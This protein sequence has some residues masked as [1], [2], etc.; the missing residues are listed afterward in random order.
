[1]P[2]SQDEAAAR[3]DSAR[4]KGGPPLRRMLI[5]DPACVQ[6]IGHNV[7]AMKYFRDSLAGHYD[8]VLAF[9]CRLLPKRA[10]ETHSLVPLFGFYYDGYLK[11]DRPEPDDDEAATS[12]E[13]GDPLE[14]MATEDSR[15][16]LRQ[17]AV[18]ADDSV[19]FPHLDFY[20]VLG[21]VNAL[22]ERPR[23]ICPTLYLRYIGVME[24]ASHGF[25]NPLAELNL[26]VREG[27]DAGLRIQLCAETPSY[28]DFISQALAAPV[29]VVPIPTDTPML[30]HPADG[31]FVFLCPGSAR[32]D[33]G[34]VQLWTIFSEIRR[35]D[36]EL[37]IRFITQ[38]LPDRDIVH[39]QNLASQLYA[40]PGVELLPTMIS[41][42]EMQRLYRRSHAV[43]LP[44]DPET[45]RYRG[46]AVMM[47]AAGCGR[48][49]LTLAGTGFAPQIAYYGL[50]RVMPTIEAM[51]DAALDMARTPRA[52]L[53][54]QAAQGRYR[55]MS[56]TVAAYKSWLRLT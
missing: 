3:A 17:F 14:L 43:L 26:R 40:L 2:H 1:M 42:A 9:C 53:E 36:P 5:C 35:R 22:L 19:F 20:G 24:N 7:A 54:R 47:E 8:A 56:D 21:M 30:P 6:M 25:R 10:A 23:E 12:A 27:L 28:A 37:T 50:G 49:A 41:A 55:F 34:F 4:V 39:W 33:K 11:I 16:L 48:P 51:I 52:V 31:P 13:F 32:H 38:T 29:S 44:Y 15:R 18:T 45:Y 46:S